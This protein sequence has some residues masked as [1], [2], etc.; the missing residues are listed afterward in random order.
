METQY[1]MI[2]ALNMTMPS[3]MVIL[4]TF[5]ADV[6]QKEDLNLSGLGVPYAVTIM[7][8]MKTLELVL[9]DH[10]LTKMIIFMIVKVVH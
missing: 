2:A 6:P 8:M 5:I 10:A 3:G 1:L 7:V 9:L 4:I